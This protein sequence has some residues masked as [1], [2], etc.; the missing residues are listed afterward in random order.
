MSEPKHQNDL[1]PRCKGSGEATIFSDFPCPVC[2]G[3]GF[4]D[5]D[6][7]EDEDTP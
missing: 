5:V 2:G 7:A 6:E 3:V 4:V 1:C